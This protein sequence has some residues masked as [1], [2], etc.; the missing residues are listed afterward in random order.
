MK[1]LA[2]PTVPAQR[3]L[4]AQSGVRELL[5]LAASMSGNTLLCTRVHQQCTA[6]CLETAH[7]SLNSAD[8]SKS[9][10]SKVN[11]KTCMCHLPDLCSQM[12]LVPQCEQRSREWLL[13]DRADPQIHL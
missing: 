11:L 12:S 6:G 10:F 4:A 2:A 3:A 9:G 7:A 13:Q 5:L 8:S 1:Q